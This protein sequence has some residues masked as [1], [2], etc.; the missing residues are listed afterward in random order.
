MYYSERFNSITHLI[1]TIFSLMGLGAL[2]TVSF[3]EQRLLLFIGFLTF[4]LTLVMLYSFSTLYHSLRDPFA[5][6]IFQKL[7]HVAIYLLI[8]G[9][10]TP[11]TLVTLIDGSGINMLIAVWSL[12]FIGISLDLLLKK[13]IELIQI[14]IY[15]IM[16][17]LVVVDFSELKEALPAA[18]IF[19]LTAGGIAYTVGI[20]FYVLDHKKTLRHAH[21]IW[22][23]FV[24]TGSI[25]HFIAIIGYVR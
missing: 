3:Y 25:S 21:G 6:R 9:T 5:K 17:W 14:A 15:L 1:G 2:M 10:Y 23:L 22:H 19:W 7:D 4:G 16:G 24:L 13:R 8:A 20:T 12:A 18:G 11:F